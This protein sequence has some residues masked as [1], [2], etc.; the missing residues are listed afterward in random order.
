MSGG[1]LNYLAF[2]M[3]DELYNKAHVHYSNVKNP[4]EATSARCDDPFED[5][6]VSE[7][8][9]DVACIIHA[10]EWYKSGDICEETYREVLSEFKK[11]YI[12]DEVIDIRVYKKALK[13][14]CHQ[15]TYLDCDSDCDLFED[16][17]HP[18]ATLSCGEEDTWVEFYLKKAR[19]QE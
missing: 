1:S 14:A 8:V 16:C 18:C 3:N 7:L 17:K 2:S 12:L 5:R 4:K 10:L 9:F 11:N 19:H 13:L 15:I 6:D